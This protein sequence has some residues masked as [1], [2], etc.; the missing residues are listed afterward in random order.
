MND[1]ETEEKLSLS[2]KTSEIKNN[3]SQMIV[4]ED[5]GY[6]DYKDFFQNKEN[7]RIS[8]DLD[9]EDE[10]MYDTSNFGLQQ[11]IPIIENSSKSNQG[12]D[13]IN[14]KR[15]APLNLDKY[16]SSY[17]TKPQQVFENN[18][19]VNDMDFFSSEKE[20]KEYLDKN[21][22]DKNEIVEENVDFRNREIV[23]DSD[24]QID[25]DEAYRVEIERIKKIR[26]MK[27]ITEHKD[28]K[29]DPAYNEVNSV[30]TKDII[31]EVYNLLNRKKIESEDHSD[32]DKEIAQ[33]EMDKLRHGMG[34][35]TSWSNKQIVSNKKSQESQDFKELIKYE[36]KE[37]NLEDLILRLKE[38]NNSE[39]VRKKS[40]FNNILYFVVFINSF[41]L[42]YLI[43]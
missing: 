21:H 7:K 16:L 12:T 35:A 22:I 23:N 30:H 14:K 39:E 13:F 41:N 40:I 10:K 28:E 20:N 43:I 36:L 31:Q 26:N 1:N 24:L 2:E 29:Y 3:K 25:L 27:R 18:F 11:V 15:K 33:W 34:A 42:I 8:V 19:E 4:E 37:V 6:L 17:T 38:E 32:S 5:E 9:Y